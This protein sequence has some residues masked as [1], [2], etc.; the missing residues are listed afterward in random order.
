MT[1]TTAPDDLKVTKVA[2]P[3]VRVITVDDISHA[4]TAGMKDFRAAPAYGLIFGAICTVIG[5]GIVHMALGTGYMFLAYPAIAGFALVAPSASVGLYEISRRLEKGEPVGWNA[6]VSA[7]LNRGGKELAYMSVVAVFG[8]LIWLDAAGFLYA[9]FFGLQP[10]DA[11]QIVVEALTTTRG[12]AFLVMGNVI[13]GIMAATLFSISVVSY[14]LLLERD[15]DFVTAM[16][17]SIRAVSASPGPMLGWGI[18][19]GTMLCIASIPMFLGLIVVLPLLGHATWHLYR[20]AVVA[21]F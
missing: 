9:I 11:G 10:L 2:E 7:V 4:L 15:I 12:L 8:M 6:V 14:P 16:I 19:I 21:E 13:G 5:L 17:T 20:R 1:E 18:F 3:R